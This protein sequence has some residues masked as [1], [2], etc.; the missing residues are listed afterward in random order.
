MPR[1]AAQDR[2]AA[3]SYPEAGNPSAKKKGGPRAGTTC[4]IFLGRAF[5]SNG[6][7]TMTPDDFRI[8]CSVFAFAFL[9]MILVRRW[10]RGR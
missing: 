9:V 10:R 1:P 2:R 4:I 8:V 7:L 3:K 6:L 5:G